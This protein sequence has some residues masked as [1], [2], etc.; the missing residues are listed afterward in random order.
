M[1]WNWNS[2]HQMNPCFLAQHLQS[3]QPTGNP[4]RGLPQSVLRDRPQSHGGIP[5]A[6]AYLQ[7]HFAGSNQGSR[8]YI[9]ADSDERRQSEER[10]AVRHNQSRDV[11]HSISGDELQVCYLAVGYSDALI[12]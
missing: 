4:R 7:Q 9:P 10:H 5:T 1:T 11:P 8:A 3:R 2:A 12:L 6:N